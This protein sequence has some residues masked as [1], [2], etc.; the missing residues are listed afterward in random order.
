V[1]FGDSISDTAIVHFGANRCTS[2]R[3]WVFVQGF[4]M[5]ALIALV[6]WSFLAGSEFQAKKFL[7][8][9]LMMC[10]AA[11]FFIAVVGALNGEW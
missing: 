2:G 3:L 6:V 10:V 9:F 5:G 4:V 1:H 8:G 7:S 11:Y